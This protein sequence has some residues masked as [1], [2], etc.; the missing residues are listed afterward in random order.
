MCLPSARDAQPV[1][2]RRVHNSQAFRLPSAGMPLLTKVLIAHED[3]EVT[4]G[5]SIL[6]QACSPRL[7]VRATYCASN[8]VVLMS[9]RNF[10]VAVLPLRSGY[11]LDEQGGLLIRQRTTSARPRLI[12]I[13]TERGDS[14][15]DLAASSFDHHFVLPKS[16]D[17]LLEA[18][19]G[20]H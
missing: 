2:Q 5:L 18:I 14:E 8:A 10:D 1:C 17:R 19:H 4:E 3:P 9:L 13:S 7:H 12:G 16:I 11:L 6:I 20:G 15:A